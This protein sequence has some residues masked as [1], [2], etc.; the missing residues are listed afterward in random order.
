M[1]TVAV[2]G[3]KGRLSHTVAKAFHAAGYRVVAV[4]RNG[5]ADGLPAGVEHRAAD[6]MNREELIAATRDAEVIFNGL[7]P[8]YTDWKAK[9]L[10]MAENVVAAAKAHGAAH[11]FAGNLYNYGHRIR[12]VADETTPTFGSTRK[13]C[14]RI[15]MEERFER[16]AREEGVQTIVLRAGDFFGTDKRGSWFDLVIAAKLD[17]GVLTYPGP[18][19][20]PHAWAYLPDLAEAFVALADRR[21]RFGRFETFNFEGHTMTGAELAGHVEAVLGHKVKRAGLPWIAI[22][23]G[24]LFNAMWREIAEMS[25]LWFTPHR[26][27]GRKL[28]AAVGEPAQTPARAAVRRALADLGIVDAGNGSCEAA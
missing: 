23:A 6:A 4:S 18:V 13:G 17:K 2:L 1:T 14:L 9:V 25:Y 21:D 8:V 11:I 15:A 12:G 7:N 22:R 20:L 24:G 3:A 10:P 19:D 26:L 28:A 27:S 5:S 16:A